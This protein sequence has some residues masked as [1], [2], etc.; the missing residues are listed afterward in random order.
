[1]KKVFVGE[2]KKIVIDK[3]KKNHGLWLDKGELQ[4]VIELSSITGRKNHSSP[5]T[6][7]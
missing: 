4:K 7:V 1:M 2:E 5:E 6:N 3:C